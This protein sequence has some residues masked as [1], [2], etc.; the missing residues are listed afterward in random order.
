VVGEEKTNYEEGRLKKKAANLVKRTRGEDEVQKKKYGL[1]TA[2][3]KDVTKKD[4]AA[5]PVMKG[6]SA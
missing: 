5:N 3:P 6:F 2:R 1:Q 4:E